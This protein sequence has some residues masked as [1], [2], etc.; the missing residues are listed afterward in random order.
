MRPPVSVTIQSLQAGPLWLDFGHQYLS[1]F[2]SC[3]R[4]LRGLMWP[5]VSQFRIYWRPR[6]TNVR[7]TGSYVRKYQKKMYVSVRSVVWSL[8]PSSASTSG[9]EG[10]DGEVVKW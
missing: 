10:W 3:N 5:Q 4:D 9:E 6:D 7:T 8:H 2:S 1:R